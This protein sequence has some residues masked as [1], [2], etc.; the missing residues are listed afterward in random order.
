M[1]VIN[2]SDKYANKKA[3]TN[4]RVDPGRFTRIIGS[5]GASG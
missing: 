4:R 3:T 1:S 2:L 5:C